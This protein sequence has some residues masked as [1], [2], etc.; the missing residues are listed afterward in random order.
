MFDASGC[1]IRAGSVNLSM[2]RCELLPSL[3]AGKRWR[4]VYAATNLRRHGE[5]MNVPHPITITT[6]SLQWKTYNDE[7]DTLHQTLYMAVDGQVQAEQD[8]YIVPSIAIKDMVNGSFVDKDHWNYTS[9]TLGLAN[10]ER[11]LPSL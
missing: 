4:I 3:A 8:L 11:T 9:R 1:E 10:G 5:V 7:L 2:L 6:S